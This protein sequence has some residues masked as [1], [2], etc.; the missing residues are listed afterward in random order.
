MRNRDVF[1]IIAIGILS[2]CTLSNNK[3]H[4]DIESHTTV[5]DDKIDS[6]KTVVVNLEEDVIIGEEKETIIEE[7]NLVEEDT[8]ST[9]EVT[10]E[11]EPIE[12][13]NNNTMNKTFDINFDGVSMYDFRE[14]M[15]GYG[16]M[17]ASFV[18]Q[19]GMKAFINYPPLVEAISK[20]PNQV[21]R[22]PGGT[23]AHF[24]DWDTEMVMDNKNKI[25]HPGL[26]RNMQ[27]SKNVK[28][29]LDEF[30][31]LCNNVGAKPTITLPIYHKDANYNINLVNRLKEKYPDQDFPMWEL[32]N[33]HGLEL[34][35]K[36]NLL[37]LEEY[38]ERCRP[39]GQHIMNVF[40]NSMV[41]VTGEGHLQR[42]RA[43]EWNSSLNDA[44]NEDPFFNSVVLHK[45]LYIPPKIQE[46]PLD[47]RIRFLF[48]GIQYEADKVA[49][50]GNDYFNGLPILLTEIGIAGIEFENP[51]QSDRTK[52][53]D[54]LW[55]VMELGNLDYML[56]YMEESQEY[57]IYAILRHMLMVKNRGKLGRSIMKWNPV[58]DP[59]NPT[60][61]QG[62]NIVSHSLLE[63]ILGEFEGGE[64]A[65][66]SGTEELVECKILKYKNKT[67]LPVRC[68]VFTK[69]NKK[70]FL[71]LNKTGEN[72]TL[73]LPNGEWGIQTLSRPLDDMPTDPEPHDGMIQNSIEQ[74]QV[75]IEGYSI[76]IGVM[77]TQ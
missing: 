43:K 62:W 57:P 27:A 75:N 6:P 61:T 5:M 47:K 76:T 24:Y 56:A 46:H 45:Y 11:E 44:N 64:Y 67:F 59:E 4:D 23:D 48:A 37:T 63:N 51:D 7:A 21:L 20:I 18:P 77:N 55:W 16:S 33:E 29:T 42:G 41:A 53:I 54:P 8:E 39:I 52:H 65:S 22:F 66:L 26:Q 74:G 36:K 30:L 32:G 2:S 9:T 38:V 40:P 31:E 70:G 15:V 19:K 73:N 12:G 3:K 28:I 17:F 60:F 13:N 10:I 69:G 1:F 14:N 25:H 49:P 72:Y 58:A 35:W 34:K 68:M 71:F 50:L